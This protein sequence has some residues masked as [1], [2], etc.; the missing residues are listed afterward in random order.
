MINSRRTRLTAFMGLILLFATVVLFMG[1]FQDQKDIHW[2]SLLFIILG[3]VLPIAGFIW[4]EDTLKAG[5][6]S[7]LRIGIYSLFFVYGVA[8]V[9]LSLLL[10]LLGATPRLLA[11]LE[12]ILILAFGLILLLAA[13]LGGSGRGS[14]R[15][16]PSVVFMRGLEE[17]VKSLSLEPANR[18][19]G[20]QLKQIGEA[21]KYSDYAGLSSMDE[22]LT[23]RLRE[24][25]YVLQEAKEED[26]PGGIDTEKQVNLLTSDILG[27]LRLRNREIKEK[28]A[29]KI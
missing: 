21:V 20:Q 14:A 23:E 7:G 4:L 2:I 6:G 16:L 12:V 29:G 24:L 27:L 19:Y 5:L 3:E 28:R 25:K 8:A 26:R 18:Q 11:T 1:I 22:G 15:T 10:L 13:A 17:E 9:S